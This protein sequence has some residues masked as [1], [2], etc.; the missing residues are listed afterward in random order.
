[1]ADNGLF[2]E[3]VPVDE[4]Q[5]ANPTRHTLAEAEP[6]TNYALVLSTCAGCWAYVL[7][8]TVRFVSTDPPR[9]LVTG[10]TS[11]FM[12][13]FGEH[14][15]GEEIE[16]AVAIGASTIET[17]ISDFSVGAVFPKT[18]N[19][20]GH[21]LYI[22]EFA[23]Y[24]LSENETAR[25]GNALE[26]VLCSRNDDYRIERMEYGVIGAPQIYPVPVGTFASWMKSRGKL[27]GQNKVPRVINDAEL[28]ANLEQFA[29]DRTAGTRT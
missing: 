3:F 14:L 4:L 22:V 18:P 2:F 28:F 19:E 16:D 13:A 9:V 24:P 1:M 27:G 23:R 29:R 25:F 10:R 7:G 5:D 20:A 12:S 15:I 17:P 6:G 11:Y 26:D 21:H 8:D